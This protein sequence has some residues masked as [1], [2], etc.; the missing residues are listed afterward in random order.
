MGMRGDAAGFWV[1]EQQPGPV[2]W[3]SHNPSPAPG[4]VRLWSLEAFAHGAG[5]VSFFRWRQAQHAQEQ[6]HSGLNRPD[7]RP[8]AAADR[9]ANRPPGDHDGHRS[10][11]VWWAQ[12]SNG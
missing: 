1:M 6:M 12:C 2:N 7:N 5:V 4:M 10:R 8:D 3:A 11:A 9:W